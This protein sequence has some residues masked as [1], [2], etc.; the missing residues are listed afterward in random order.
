MLRCPFGAPSGIYC[1]C[2][3]GATTPTFGA[4]ANRPKGPR[5][6]ASPQSGTPRTS[7]YIPLAASHVVGRG[8][9][10]RVP[11]PY[12]ISGRLLCPSLSSG[13][14][15]SSDSED[16][17]F[18]ATTL[19][20]LQYMPKGAPFGPLERLLALWAYIALPKGA[21][22]YPAIYAQRAPR[23][24]LA[25]PIYARSAYCTFRCWR[26]TWESGPL[27]GNESFQP[28]G[29]LCLMRSPKG[30]AHTAPLGAGK[31]PGRGLRYW[32]EAPTFG[33]PLGP[34]S[35][36]APP[37]RN[38]CLKGP[39]GAIL[40][41]LLPK[42]GPFGHILRNER[43]LC[44]KALGIYWGPFGFSLRI[45]IYA[46]RVSGALAPSGPLRAYI[47]RRTSGL[48][49]LRTESLQALAV[50]LF[51]SIAALPFFIFFVCFQQ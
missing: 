10:K 22:A 8:N 51:R 25:S 43:L 20:C 35:Y 29:L 32:C 5:V 23:R 15:W 40:A 26:T 24:L 17:P 2:P 47:A 49:A 33:P 19:I 39:F 21:S 41:L 3:E 18:G 36:V 12:L 9:L 28:F 13:P 11:S 48:K 6:G 42:G 4:R 37:D 44:L 30:R 16:C 50:S 27:W 38:I 31:D 34:A 1:S 7:A 14:L 46:Q 45:S